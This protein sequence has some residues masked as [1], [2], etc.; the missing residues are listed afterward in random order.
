MKKKN[1]SIIYLTGNKLSISD[2]IRIAEEYVEV[3][4]D[5]NTWDKIKKGR[6]QLE[7]QLEERPDIAIYGTNRLHGDLKDKAVSNEMIKAYQVK[8]VQVH[9]CGTGKALPENVVRAMMV[10]RLNSFAKGLSG[11]K[12]DTCQLMLDLLNK[13]V[14]PWILEEGTVGA[15]G[16]LV[17]LSMLSATMIALP[18]AKA[19]YNGKLLSAKKALAKAGLK[20]VVLGAKEA[21][22]IS[23][24]ANFIAAWAAIGVRD[25]KRIMDNASITAALSLEA[26]RGEQ[27]AFSTLINEQSNRHKGQIYIARQIR[28]LIRNSKRTSIEAQTAPFGGHQFTERVQDRYSFRC[29]PQINGAAYEAYLKLK[30]TVETEINSATD[31]PL[32]DFDREDKR[33]GGIWFASGGNF[34]G[35]ALATVIDYMKIALTSV[36]LLSDKRCFSLLDNRLSY[37]LPPSLAYDVQQADGGLMLTQY[38]GAARAAENRVLSSPASIT[39]VSTSANQEDYVSMGS[40]GVLHLHKIIYNTQVILGI[41]LLCALRAL[42]L[43]FDDLPPK[44]QKLGNQTQK[45]Y[46]YLCQTDKLP[47]GTPKDKDAHLK[48][49]YLRLDMEKAV[50]IIRSGE[51]TNFL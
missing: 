31:N 10:I 28:K 27:K 30:D 48:D 21:M 19:Y 29:V 8:Y 45:I 33:T 22:G 32:F 40:I 34:H 25:V 39:S 17:P 42:Q 2:I 36:G 50:E 12:A 5:D 26:I 44:L 35:Q 24:G 9:N 11:M 1:G 38:A 3:D 4:F 37:G 18:E 49:H 47:A 14:T 13:K 7:K 16:D 6:G 46:D 15:S 41:E 23:N 20:P 43:T 51:L